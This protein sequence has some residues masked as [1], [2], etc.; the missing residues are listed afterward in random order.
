MTA[1]PAT[2]TNAVP[3]NARPHGSAGSTSASRRAKL[4]EAGC[5]LSLPDTTAP[6]GEPVAQL[7]RIGHSTEPGEEAVVAAF[8]RRWRQDKVDGR[9]DDETRKLIA[10]VASVT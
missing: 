6:D 7:K 10:R 9:I 4:A 2:V 1:L 8:Q 3:A 5:A